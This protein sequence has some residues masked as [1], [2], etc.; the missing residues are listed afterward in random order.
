M[1]F[2]DAFHIALSDAQQLDTPLGKPRL[3]LPDNST[4]DKS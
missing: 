3:H 4:E 1:I 2:G